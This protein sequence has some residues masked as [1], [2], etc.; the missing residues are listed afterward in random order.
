M[1]VKVL[2]I[3]HSLCHL[4]SVVV[5]D[6]RGAQEVPKREGQEWTTE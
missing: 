1:G 5:D 3:A 6:Y 4:A 2:A